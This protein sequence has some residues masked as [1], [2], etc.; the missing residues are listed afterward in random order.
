MI[1]ASE[2]F[3]RKA[4]NGSVNKLMDKTKQDYDRIAWSAL[5]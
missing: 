4:T 1:Y 5:V 3:I 2:N